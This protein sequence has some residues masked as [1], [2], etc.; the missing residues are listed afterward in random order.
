MLNV[1]YL[2]LG[3][4]FDLDFAL[5]DDQ[6]ALLETL[7]KTLGPFDDAYWSGCDKA[8]TF[9]AEFVAAMAD[10]GW[11]GIA[12]PESVGGSGLGMVE[13]AMMMQAVAARGGMT[14]A[15]AIHMNIFGPHALVAHGTPEQRARWLP[16]IISGKTRMCFAVTE[17]DSGLDTSRLKTRAVRQGA[18]YI[19]NGHKVWTSTARTADKIM[20]IARTAERDPQ[21][22][23]AGLSLFFTDMDRDRIDVREIDKMGR[24]A[25]DTNELFIDDFEIPVDDLVGEKGLGFRYLLHSLNPERILIAAEAVG[26]GLDALGRATNYARDRVVFERPIGMNQSIQHPLAAGWAR[27]EAAK[28]AMM[29]AAWLFDTG[30]PCGI[31]AN[32]AK[33]LAAEAAMD[34]CRHAVAT[35]GGMGYAREFHVERLYREIMIPYLA[36]VSQQMV[37]N[38]IAERTLGLPKSY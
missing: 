18:K 27:L 38:F 37:L 26:I 4:D 22:P 14:A 10:G 34:V 9:P 30:Q 24:K 13:A 16:H 5:S 23:T 20:L 32:A 29:K 25:V 21:N 8:G 2:R 15:S 12:L 3:E 17:P 7:D 36:P 35:H 33:Y 11:L 28:L 6:K 1:R 19:V 31:E